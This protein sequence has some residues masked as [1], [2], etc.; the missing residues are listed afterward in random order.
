M[1]IA[2]NVGFLSKQHLVAA[3]AM[4]YRKDLVQFDQRV[5]Q[6]SQVISTMIASICT[7]VSLTVD[8]LNNIILLLC[9]LS[10]SLVYIYFVNSKNHDDS[11][12]FKIWDYVL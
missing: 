10:I 11:T 5:H 12:V 1:H 7:S 9:P 4:I 2:S 6:N 8:E 3:V